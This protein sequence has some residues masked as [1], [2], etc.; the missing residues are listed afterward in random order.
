M[1]FYPTTIAAISTAP[2]VG[3]VAV[4]RLSGPESLAVLKRVFQ[5]LGRG[6]WEPRRMRFGRVINPS[7]GALVDEA[8]A[9]WFPAPN[10]FTGE[11]V[12][13]IQGHGG[14]VAA[15]RVLKAVLAAGAE[16]AA[17]GE[18][19]RRAFMNG[20]LD[21]AQAEAVAD[22]IAARS[23]AEAALAA[24]QLSGR[25][26]ER[27]ENIHK[28]I[29]SALADL[30]ADIDFGEELNALDMGRFQARLA[31]IAARLEQLLEEG[32]AGKP[33]R[34]GLRLALAGAPN[35]GKSSLFNALANDERALVSP[36]PGT[37]RD[38]ITTEALWDGLWVEL[39]D[40]AGLSETP[41]D[42]LDALGQERAR[43]QLDR[44][45]V[46]LWVGDCT[47]PDDVGTGQ[48]LPPPRTLRVWNKADLSPPPEEEGR[49]RPAPAGP[50]PMP[51]IA[52][53]A[54]TGQGL[55]DLKAAILRLATG[56]E[57]PKPPEV[58]PNLRHQAILSR[59]AQ[60]LNASLAAAR[61]GQP[62]D[63]CAY[64]LR[65]ALDTLG[66]IC[67]RTA[68]DDILN[69]IFSRFCLGK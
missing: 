63:I 57:S 19:T 22:L 59:T 18:F 48:K 65:T 11:E 6:D 40:T 12:A 69:E 1:S 27:V 46:I 4:V 44:A 23:E 30:E 45:D 38:F 25:L 54:R 21:L 47:R 17:P 8:L 7:D 28:D 5:P 50:E 15:G 3:A 10:S 58:S 64:E 14:P 62:P 31:E 51:A 49:A 41:V 35:V 9:V 13:E 43:A 55:D 60:A 66:A 16:L 52:V 32:R 42:E 67:G 2:A 68:P 39:C 33:F 56:Q 36:A 24:R 61:A 37:T 53:S 34:D 29:I 26:S 20:R